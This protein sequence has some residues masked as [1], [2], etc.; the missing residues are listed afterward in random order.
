MFAATSN[1]YGFLPICHEWELRVVPGKG[2]TTK[3]TI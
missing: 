2:E 1:Y 3:R